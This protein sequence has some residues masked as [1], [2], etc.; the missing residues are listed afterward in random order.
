MGKYIMKPIKFFIPYSNCNVAKKVFLLKHVKI[1][2]KVHL[3]ILVNCHRTVAICNVHTWTAS[4][5]TKFASFDLI[6]ASRLTLHKLFPFILNIESIEIRWKISKCSEHFLNYFL[7]TFCH[8]STSFA[9]KCSILSKRHEKKTWKRTFLKQLE[10][11]CL[12][13]CRILFLSFS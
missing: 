13:T 12:F 5:Q 8:Y 7:S 2:L 4:I 9:I 6:Y 3:H 1:N 11:S 10:C